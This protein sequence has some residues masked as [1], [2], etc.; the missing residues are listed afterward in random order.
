MCKHVCLSKYIGKTIF[1]N[2]LSI[3]GIL[4]EPKRTTFKSQFSAFQAS[5][6]DRSGR[7]ILKSADRMGR[8]TCTDVHALTGRRPVDPCGRPDQ[9]ALLSVF[10]GRPDRSTGGSN[11]RIFDRWR[12]TGRS[13][14]RSDRPQRLY[15]SGL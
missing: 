1:V 6:A 14:G 11:G 9:R 2:F 10:L 15:F 4:F 13:T 7:P 3:Y 8:P 12:S 5:A